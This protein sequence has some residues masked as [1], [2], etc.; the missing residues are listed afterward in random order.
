MNAALPLATVG[1]AFN[2]DFAEDGFQRPALQ[3]AMSKRQDRVA[4]HQGNGGADVTRTAKIHMGLQKEALNLAALELL[5]LFDEVEW[6]RLS[7]RGNEP[8]FEIVKGAVGRSH[9]IT[10]LLP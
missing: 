6:R 8:L 1:H 5:L 2:G 7:K 9:M 10:V 4:L 3:S